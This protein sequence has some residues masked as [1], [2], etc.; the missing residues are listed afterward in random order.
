FVTQGAVAAAAGELPD[1]ALA[2]VWGLVRSAQSE[3]PGRFALVD[4]D[5][6]EASAAAL[7]RVLAASADEP[8]LALRDGAALVPRLARL[9][10]E[11]WLEPPDVP[12][13]RLAA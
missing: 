9:G 7:E 13:W 5:G 2:A 10:P 8:Q 11:R 6:S 1:P 3:H 12:A 4:L